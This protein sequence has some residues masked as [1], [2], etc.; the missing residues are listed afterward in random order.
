MRVQDIMR[1]S[2][3]FCTPATN[4]AIAAKLL[5]SAAC[6]ALP[7]V[8]G[9]RHVVGII[10]HR[11]ISTTL[12]R[13]NQPASDVAV[14][15]AMSTNVAVCRPAHDVHAAL[16]MMSNRRI[17]HVPVVTEAGALEGLLCIRE[18]ILHARHNDGTRPDLSY[19]DVM[20]ALIS[21]YC[22]RQPD[23][24]VSSK[25]IVSSGPATR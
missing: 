24:V 12:G 10:T 11:D 25:E 22:H 9:N 4:L 5:R 8:D 16:R 2:P 3:S 6:E 18:I 19:E 21:I 15:E 14:A 7:I 1:K 20:G 23:A 17:R 13:R